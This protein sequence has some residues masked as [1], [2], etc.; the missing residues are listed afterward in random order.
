MT[1]SIIQQAF[2]H[3][4]KDY[5]S[6]G[7]SHDQAVKN[8]LEKLQQELIEKIKQE[9][10]SDSDVT[11]RLVVKRLIGDNKEWITLSVQNVII[12]MYHASVD[13]CILMVY[14]NR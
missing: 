14:V 2:R 9:I 4:I 7:Y 13:V 10:Q 8:D 1:D 5:D 11:I 12:P 6:N 3:L